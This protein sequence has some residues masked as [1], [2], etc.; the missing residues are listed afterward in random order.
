ML[1]LLLCACLVFWGGPL[2]AM[3]KWKSSDSVEA[4]GVR[5][6]QYEDNRRHRP[7]VVELWYPIEGDHS[8]E[9]LSEEVWKHPKESRNAPIAEGAKGLPLILMSH[10]HCG[11][12]RDRSWLAERLVRA[13]FIVASVDHYGNTRSTFNP[14][15]TIKFWDRP[16]DISF[17]LDRLLQE[18]SLTGRVD[19]EKIGFAGYSLGGMT[20]LGIG[21]GIP[22]KLEELIAKNKAKLSDIPEEVLAQIDF[23]EAGSNL[24][25]PRIRAILLIAPA[26]FVYSSNALKRIKVPIGLVS[27]INDEVLPHHEHSSLII[28]HVVPFKLKILRK[29]ISHYAFLN[30]LSE[31]GR[32]ILPAKFCSDPPCCDRA[33]IH[34]DVG[35]F[36][37]EFFREAFRK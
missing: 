14:L 22:E 24:R 8:I 1:Q 6:F 36:A 32:K 9:S 29:E 10:G 27:A 2:Q 23:K 13:N 11:D 18:P 26:N 12:R 25:D 16:R 28:Q 4:I 17:A 20:G 33:S 37:I 15:L 31:I 5:T 30:P 34:R 21:G 35:N 7:V 19:P 3:S